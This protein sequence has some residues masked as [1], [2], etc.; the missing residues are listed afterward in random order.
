[1][2]IFELV[3]ELAV[4]ATALFMMGVHTLWY[5]LPLLKNASSHV[6][7]D[8][9][10]SSATKR[11][12]IERMLVTFSGYCIVLTV[13]AYVL[14]LAPILD[15]SLGNIAVGCVLFAIGL[16]ISVCAASDHARKDAIA[17]TGFVVLSNVGGLCRIYFRPR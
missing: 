16:C 4:F 8:P 10:T 7:N 6:Q 9:E 1:M 11:E 17:M 3:N 12:M 15:L 13:I 5:S 2:N 14:A